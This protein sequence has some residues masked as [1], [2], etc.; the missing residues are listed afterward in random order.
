[1]QKRIKN[2]IKETY[3]LLMAVM[4][5][6]FVASEFYN[7]YDLLGIIAGAG[8]TPQPQYVLYAIFQAVFFG[9]LSIVFPSVL[10]MDALDAWKEAKQ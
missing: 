2:G 8:L 3:I 9:I 4:G 1:M 5:W 6:I 7:F 10:V